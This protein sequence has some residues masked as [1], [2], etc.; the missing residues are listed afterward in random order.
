MS[1]DDDITKGLDRIH[2]LL[3]DKLQ[4][5]GSIKLE[6]S[7]IKSQVGQLNTQVGEIWVFIRGKGGDNGLS[8]RVRASEDGLKSLQRSLEKSEEERRKEIEKLKEEVRQLRSNIETLTAF[9]S[10]SKGSKAASLEASNK[11]F[12]WAGVVGAVGTFLYWLVDLIMK[13]K[14]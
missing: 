3:D 9:K 1:N 12:Q 10:E 8:Y 2:A 7:Q 13:S 14:K 4:S 6:V 11:F 5:L